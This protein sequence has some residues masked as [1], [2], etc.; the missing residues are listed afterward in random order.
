[1]T[2][3]CLEQL[4]GFAQID[5][6]LLTETSNWP[7]VVTD[8]TSA[9]ITFTPEDIQIE[10]VI[11][12]ESISVQASPRQTA[13]GTVWDIDINF[14]FITRSESIEQLME[15]YC[16]KPGVVVGKLNT[17]F[18]KL[19]GTNEEP[20]YM[21]WRVDEGQKATDNAGTIVAIKGETRNRPV[22]YTP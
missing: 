13:E 22:F 15:Q 9:G 18:Q 3:N 10:G 21:T 16:N 2:F 19:Y 12:D 7:L 8:Q 11:D 6:F 17:G 4:A 1:M 14:R 20:L 5:F